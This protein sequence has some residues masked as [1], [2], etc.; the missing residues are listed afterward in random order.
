MQY[1]HAKYADNLQCAAMSSYFWNSFALFEHLLPGMVTAGLVK[2]G[3]IST[4][5]ESAFYRMTISLPE[6]AWRSRVTI[7]SLVATTKDQRD[8][9]EDRS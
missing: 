3:L 9:N 8:W 2:D 4:A 7:P 5:A 6:A 1:F